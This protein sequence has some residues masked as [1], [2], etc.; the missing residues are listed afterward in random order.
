MLG[1][2]P[3]ATEP[4]TS[5]NGQTSTSGDDP[6]S[7]TT[8]AS[9]GCV[10]FTGDHS[11]PINTGSPS[12]DALHL[13]GET[14]ICA[15]DVVVV[16]PDDLNEVAAAAQLAAAVGGP[17]LFPDPRLAA[18]LGRLDPR[19]VHL[20]GSP[21][22][23]VPSAAESVP[24]DVAGAIQ[25]AIAALGGAD[26]V[27]TP[28][29]PAAETIV[30]TALAIGSGERV[31][32]PQAAPTVSSTAAPAPAALD[33]AAI[34]QGLAVPSESESLWVVDVSQPATILLASAF[35]KTLG[36]S[37]IAIDGSNVLGHPEVG[38]ALAGRPPESTR[39][40]GGMP[41]GSE[42]ELRLLVSG[43]QVPGGGFHVF[44]EDQP[45]R[46]VAFYGHPETTG[47]GVLGEQGPAETLQRMGEFLEA[48]AADGAQII[49]TFEMIA[50][51][52]AAGPTD[53]GDYSFEWPIETYR[54]WV[55]F[56]TENGMYVILDLQSGRDDFLTQAKMYE[57]L[58]LLPNVSLALD[59]EWRLGPDQTH[60][61][62]IGTVTAAEVNTVIDWLSTLVRDN[63]L[64]QK[65]LIV[66]QFR[67]T[68]IQN[69]QD[70]KQV[71]ELQ[72][73]IQMDG[74]GGAGG[75]ATKD[76]TW[77][78]LTA[79]TEDAHWKWG[80][81]NFFDEDEPGPPPPENVIRKVPTPVFVSYQ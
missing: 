30:E 53:D 67:D 68:M 75:E 52:A 7:T 33:S 19:R 74:E 37:V 48:Y 18:E 41:A 77:N 4:G 60:L 20:V 22:V 54:P 61:N 29:V 1:E 26:S 50:A 35:A 12:T 55:D 31:A 6:S 11:S 78:K 79:G 66:H 45:R 13:S 5:G 10:R 8:P 3:V 65:M 49:P 46:F 24:L 62:Q 72:L 44:P 15:D 2:T 80:W 14:F 59:P 76:A 56:A 64:P 57:E 21:E 16:R 27:A 63:G 23:N 73:V 38:T 28:A 34:V 40:L 17:L 81:K 51:V 25:S 71:P 58:L 9:T 36:A 47:L 70:L 43:Q 32:T 42:W 39:F 69:R